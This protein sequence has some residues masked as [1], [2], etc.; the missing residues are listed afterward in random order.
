M[1]TIGFLAKLYYLSLNWNAFF[2][3]KQTDWTGKENCYVGKWS[4]WKVFCFAKTNLDPRFNAPICGTWEL[5]S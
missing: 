1:I 4:G 3:G 5:E 2:V